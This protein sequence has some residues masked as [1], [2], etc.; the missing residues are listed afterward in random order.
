VT[1][2]GYFDASE[3]GA[4]HISYRIAGTLELVPLERYRKQ[5]ERPGLLPMIFKGE[6]YRGK[7]VVKHEPPPVVRIT[8][9]KS[10]FTSKDGKVSI[11]AEA[12]SRGEYPVTSFR[13]KVNGKPHVKNQGLLDVDKPRVGKATAKW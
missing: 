2:D 8:S 4:R 11:T 7:A 12:Q 10:G 5:F 13:L 9:P 3:N 1:P 6:D